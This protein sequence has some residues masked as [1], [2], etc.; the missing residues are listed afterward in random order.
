MNVQLDPTSMKKSGE[1]PTAIVIGAGFGGIALAIRLQ[2][3]GFQTTLVD[4]RDK[5]GGR[6]YVYE[7][8]GYKF[9]GGPTVITDP[10]C[11]RE[12]FEISGRNMDDYVTL[13]PVDPFYRLQWEDG[14]TFDYNNDDAYLEQQIRERNPDD[15]AGYHKFLNYS[16]ELYREGYEKLGTTAFLKMRQMFAAAPQLVRLRA[17]R[18]VYSMVSKFVKNERVRQLL[19]FQSLLVGGNPFKTSSIYALIHALERRDG[20]WFAKGGTGA[21]VQG[22]IQLFEDL[23]GELRLD[24]EITDIQTEGDRVVGVTA[25]DGWSATADLISSNADVV[26]TYSQLLRKHSRGQKYG[27]AL[28]RKSHSMSLF[29]IYFGLKTEHPNLKHHIILLGNR[30]KDLIAEIFGKGRKLP[31][32]FSLYLHAPCVTDKSM[33]PKGCSSYYVLSPVPHLGHADV[34]WDEV[35]PKYTQKILDYIETHAIPNLNRDLTVVKTLTPF[36]FRDEMNS[37]LGSAF[38]VEPILTQSAWF[39]P[40]NRDDVIDNLYITG[41]GTHPGAGVPGVV[42]AAKATAGV[43]E[44]DFDGQLSAYKAASGWPSNQ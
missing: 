44:G 19:S 24:T 18:S 43:I 40:H 36:G 17:D 21:L 23:G 15:V 7:E 31:D 3:M 25:A 30:Y 16:K 28:K 4:N 38:S 33:A 6:A 12:L 11:L 41:A 1:K 26:H 27:K 20:V 29:V 32:D 22:C 2:T 34:D 37:H 42:G 14:D 8:D 9:D 35:G 5:P 10:N 39:R 13:L